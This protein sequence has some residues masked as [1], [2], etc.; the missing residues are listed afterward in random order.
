MLGMTDTSSPL[1]VAVSGGVDSVVMLDVLAKSKLRPLVVAHVD[2]GIRPDSSEDAAFVAQQAKHYG[3][4]FVSTKLQLS[5]DASEDVARR[6]RYAWL[7]TVRAA[8]QASAIAT[9]HHED[10][11]LETIAINIV[12]GTGWR[13]L[14]SLRETTMR[15]RPLLSHSK[16]WIIDYAL[17]H[18]LEWREDSTNDS[19]KYLRNR[20]RYAVTPRL[21]PET[22]QQLLNLYNSQLIL[23]EKIDNELTSLRSQYVIEGAIER[24]ALVMIEDELAIE[25]L[26]GWLGESLEQVRFRDL[27]LFAKTARAGAKWSL[28]GRRFVVAKQRTLI[29]ELPRD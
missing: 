16:A 4:Q 13:G 26:R 21:G 18:G 20:I 1:V 25:L 15:H 3:L 12:R 14:C 19:L 24:Y 5:A 23:R 22:R 28:D 2:H 6:A 29:V 27:L 17:T 11:I 7:E 9:A 10:D 8:H